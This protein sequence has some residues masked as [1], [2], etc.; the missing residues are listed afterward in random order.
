MHISIIATLA[1]CAQRKLDIIQSSIEKLD[2][3][4]S[5]SDIIADL[6]LKNHALFNYRNFS[7]N[8]LF[9]EDSVYSDWIKV[10]TLISNVCLTKRIDQSKI[11]ITILQSD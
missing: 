7:L 8:N 11:M 5:V 3:I 6:F 2:D 1:I 9:V 4:E 10:Q